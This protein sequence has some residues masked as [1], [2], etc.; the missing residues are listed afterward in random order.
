[1]KGIL[2]AVFL[3][4]LGG[5]RFYKGN[6][7]LG[8][9]YLLTLGL[10]GIGWVVDIIIAVRENNNTKDNRKEITFSVAGCNY[11][12]EQ[13]TLLGKERREWKKSDSELLASGK[14]SVFRYSFP[15]DAELIPEPD[16]IYDK[17]A[18]A[19]VV[20]G[21]KIGHVPAAL[22]EQVKPLIKKA[23]GVSC[24]ISGGDYK[25]IEHGHVDTMFYDYS[26]SVTIHR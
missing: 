16:N 10:C 15:F 11:Y 21:Q 5:Y 7:K 25:R 3:G 17:N 8:I 24:R 12:R 2:I 26:A 22:C 20:E 4:W 1:M 18:I 6:K 13:I 14:D 19:V 9:L 23:K